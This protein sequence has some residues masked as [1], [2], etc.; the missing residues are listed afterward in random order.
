MEKEISDLTKEELLNPAFIPSIFE[1]Y[2]DENERQNI[3]I[4]VLEVAKDKG[5]W[6]KLKMQ[7]RSA[8][9]KLKLLTTL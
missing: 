6:V 1:G 4:E 5:C 7:Y 3:L 8:R 2:T 9:M